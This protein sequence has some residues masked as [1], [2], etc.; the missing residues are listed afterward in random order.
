MSV[1]CRNHHVPKWYLT[2]PS[3]HLHD[4]PSPNFERKG[5]VGGLKMHVCSLFS[6]FPSV[7][8]A[9]A[10]FSLCP[11]L[12]SSTSTLSACLAILPPY[13]VEK[14]DT[15]FSSNL[16]SYSWPSIASRFKKQLLLPY[17]KFDLLQI[18]YTLVS[19]LKVI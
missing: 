15:P 7:H 5:W 8:P 1:I 12:I 18:V 13:L 6:L 10:F 4:S 16:L 2:I 17:S 19:F 9:L 14:N 11:P 3:P